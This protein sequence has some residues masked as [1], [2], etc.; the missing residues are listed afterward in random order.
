MLKVIVLAAMLLAVGTMC[1]GLWWAIHPG[2][3]IGTFDIGDNRQVRIWSE[4][5]WFEPYVAIYYQISEADKLLCPTTYL[6]HD[7][8]Q[9]FDFRTAFS[10]DGKLACVYEVTLA[11]TDSDFLIIYD[12]VNQESW[13][14]MG[15]ADQ[16]SDPRVMKKWR[17]RYRRLRSANPEFPKVRFFED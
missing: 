13:P 12:T 4:G 17:D 1:C 11:V 16:I 2:R 6:N 8:G 3:S 10:D 14:R 5:K 9:R 7:H 15:Y